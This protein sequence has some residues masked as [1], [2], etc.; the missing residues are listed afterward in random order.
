MHSCKPIK[1]ILALIVL[2]LSLSLSTT[3]F[4]TVA[5]PDVA[6][7]DAA[8]V[9]KVKAGMALFKANCASC[10]AIDKKIIGPALSGVWDRWESE[11]KIDDW[12]H[13]PSKFL[14][15]GDPYA[16]VL[17]GNDI[18][19]AMTAFPQFTSE[20]IMNILIYVKNPGV[21]EPAKAATTDVAA[22]GTDSKGSSNWYIWAL[23]SFLAILALLL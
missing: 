20:Q 7:S 18:T 2:I 10:H 11:A 5:V 23:I 15:S 12:I 8:G 3:S 4:A 19:S 21:A 1:K 17:K 6:A 13:N 9:E 14:D 16:Q 22:T